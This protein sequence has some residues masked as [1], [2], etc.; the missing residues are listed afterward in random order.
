M[1]GS[2]TRFYDING[3]TQYL[4]Q[5]LQISVGVDKYVIRQHYIIIV[6]GFCNG[7]V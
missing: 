1:P 3:V 4:G 7:S 5:N 6:L 2:S